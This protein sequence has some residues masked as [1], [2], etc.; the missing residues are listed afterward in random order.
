GCGYLR[1]YRPLSGSYG[2]WSVVELPEI[3]GTAT[4][5]NGFGAVES[6]MATSINTHVF[7][8]IVGVN[9][10]LADTSDLR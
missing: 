6:V 2:R 9:T 8:E 7:G 5:R 3:C 4:K 1:H 10:K